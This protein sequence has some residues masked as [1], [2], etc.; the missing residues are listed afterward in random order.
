MRA[1]YPGTFDPIT[2]GHTDIVRRATKLFG[3]VIVAVAENRRKRPLFDLKT[4]VR[5]A[6][7]VLSGIPQCTVMGFDTLLM[8]FVHE[9]GADVIIRGLRAVSDFEYEFQMA[10]MN[11]Q[12]DR[13]IETVFLTPCEKEAYLSATLVKE[14]AELGGNVD[15]FVHPVVKDALQSIL[16]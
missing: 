1:I 12:L 11:R 3:G 16:R 4:R 9:Q 7:E 13:Q 10:A 8:D 2:N 6:R 14:I 15:S 5:L